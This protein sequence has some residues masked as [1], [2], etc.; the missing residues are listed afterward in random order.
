MGACHPFGSALRCGKDCLEGITIIMRNTLRIAIV[1]AAL[2]AVSFAS[3]A[4][5]ATSATAN[6]S[7]EV[8][9][10]LTLAANSALSFGQIAANTGGS[11][12][13]NADSTVTSSGSLVSTGTRAPAGFTVTGTPNANVVLT[14]PSSATLTRSGGTE[15]MSIAG[16]NSNPGGAFQLGA[17]G[18]SNFA[19]G[20]TLTVAS[21]QVSGTYNGTFAV[22]VEYQ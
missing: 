5:A 13:V 12:T 4:S 16:F 15:T 8:L 2:G 22:S 11:V 7:A 3:A 19:V 14:L 10:T 18:S 6:A 21:G 20:G 1:G 9:S 17:T